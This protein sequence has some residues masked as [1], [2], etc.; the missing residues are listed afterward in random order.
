ML[1]CWIFAL[2]L[3]GLRREATL[4][5]TTTATRLLSLQERSIYAPVEGGAFGRL[6]DESMRLRSVMAS[7]G[8]R[9]SD[10]DGD[11]ELPV[12]AGATGSSVE[13]SEAGTGTGTVEVEAGEEGTPVGTGL[14]GVGGGVGEGCGKG[15]P[16][17]DFCWRGDHHGTWETKCTTCIKER[18]AAAKATAVTPDSATCIDCNET[19]AAE[20]FNKQMNGNLTG[21]CKECKYELYRTDLV[22]VLGKYNRN[23]NSNGIAFPFDDPIKL[24]KLG[25]MLKQKCFFCDFK[26]EI[27]GWLNGLDR[28]DPSIGYDVIANV[29]SCCWDCNKRKGTLNVNAF[30]TH[31]RAIVAHRGLDINAA[32]VGRAGTTTVTG[33]DGEGGCEGDRKANE[34]TRAQELGIWFSKCAYC[35]RS[36]ASGIDRKDSSVHYTPGNTCACCTECNFMKNSLS[37]EEFERQISNIYRH[38]AYWVMPDVSRLPLTLYGETRQPVAVL[39]DNGI[40]VIFPS[41]KCAALI[42]GVTAYFIGRDL[43]EGVLGDKWRYATAKEYRSQDLSADDCRSMIER[44]QEAPHPPPA[45]PPSDLPIVYCYSHL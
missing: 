26:D 20:E 1:A 18:D 19:K 43:S 17:V 41:A 13:E 24:G 36:P 45:L 6:R 42:T 29:V 16:E 9:D 4:P 25:A 34:L 28:V 39:M 33:D 30:I 32:Q 38:T 2:V 27:R 35:G 14:Q 31:V 15:W 8:D 44:L 5:T 21:Q 12:L 11:G 22:K 7:V 23:A 10:R 3:Y 37:V 40:K